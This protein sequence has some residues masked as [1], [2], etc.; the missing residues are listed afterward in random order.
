MVAVCR[1]KKR[2]PWSGAQEV[3]LRPASV[4]GIA[5]WIQGTII[6]TVIFVKLKLVHITPALRILQKLPIALMVKV[7]SSA[8]SDHIH[9][10]L[11]PPPASFPR[12]LPSFILQQPWSTHKPNSHFAGSH[13]RLGSSLYLK[14]LSLP[15][16]P[17]HWFLV[18]M[19]HFVSFARPQGI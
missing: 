10:L 15:Y 6:P 12:L 19:V 3:F 11:Q 14:C 8:G 5:A 18:V 17:M 4:L 2:R 13:L 1:G 7:S 16:L 9:D